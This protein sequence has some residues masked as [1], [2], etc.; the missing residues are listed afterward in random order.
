MRN[1]RI[2]F[3][4]QEKSDLLKA[5]AA[6]SLA[7]AIVYIHRNPA[8][9]QTPITIIIIALSAAVTVG[10]GFI[11]HELAH[12]FVAIYHGCSAEF[13]AN[14]TML[15]VAIFMSFFGWVFAAPGAV[16]VHGARG[17]KEVGLI[18][19]AGPASNIILALIFLIL[20]FMLPAELSKIAWYGMIIN[21][22]LALFNMI[23][24][25]PFDGRKVWLWNKTIYIV[26]AALAVVFAFGQSFLGGIL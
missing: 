11:L 3:T 14:N 15:W 23:P 16:M 5:W 6:I 24:V 22:M 10:L 7:F 1:T 13:R 9:L 20:T 19:A 17:K 4:R 2:T 18:S 25:M 26:L 8:A 12:K 21:G